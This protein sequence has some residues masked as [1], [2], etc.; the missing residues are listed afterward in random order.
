M[1]RQFITW[2]PAIKII[3]IF[4][5]LKED[6]NN[7]FTRFSINSTITIKVRKS[8]KSRFASKWKQ[9]A[10]AGLKSEIINIIIDVEFLLKI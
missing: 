7:D 8:E 10:V 5:H 4:H 6:E 2:E 1:F 9:L 3:V